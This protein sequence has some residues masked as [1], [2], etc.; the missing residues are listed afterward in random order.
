MDTSDSARIAGGSAPAGKP[1][2]EKGTY[3]AGGRGR[4]LLAR[5]GEGMR[6][7]CLELEP[8]GSREGE[9]PLL[10]APGSMGTLVRGPEHPWDHSNVDNHGAGGID[11]AF[12]GHPFIRTKTVLEEHPI[13]Q[14]GDDARFSIRPAVV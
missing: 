12:V 4:G 8:E 14:D 1:G 5:W 11:V 13:S 7:P 3:G 9:A 6:A 2:A 10:C